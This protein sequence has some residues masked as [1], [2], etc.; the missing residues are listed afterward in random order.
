MNHTGT[1]AVLLG[2]VPDTI[3][4]LLRRL[5]NGRPFRQLKLV[6]AV[7]W[8]ESDKGLRVP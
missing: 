7:R 4:V 8:P 1:N 2:V 6:V 3:H 5:E